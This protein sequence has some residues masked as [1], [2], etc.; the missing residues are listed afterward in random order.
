MASHLTELD[1]KYRLQVSEIT[2][3]PGGYT[4][5]YHHVGPGI[6]YVASGTLTFEQ[7]GKTT[8]YKTG[9][10]VYEAGNSTNAAYNRSNE[11]V[12]MINFET[13]PSGWKGGS[14]VLPPSQ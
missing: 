7:E 3:E 14:A 13:L 4:G 12:R 9:D 1:G 6:R 5:E 10:Y 2:S 8:T 11:P